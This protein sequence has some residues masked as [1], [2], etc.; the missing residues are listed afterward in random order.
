[1][2]TAEQRIDQIADCE[3]TGKDVPSRIARYAQLNQQLAHDIAR[4]LST[5]EEAAHAAML[6]LKGHPMLAGVD[7]R[8]RARRVARV[9]REARELCQGISAECVAFN[10]QFRTEFAEA[11]RV[12]RGVKTKEYRGKVQP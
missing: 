10:L 4:E 7:V 11:L 3:F 2:S 6:Q 9:L 12:D 5:A 8:W 1:M